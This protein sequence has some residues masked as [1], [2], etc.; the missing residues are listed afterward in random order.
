M[1]LSRQP[2]RMLL[3]DLRFRAHACVY[4]YYYASLF[5]RHFFYWSNKK[6]LD[7]CI[8]ADKIICNSVEL[9][10]QNVTRIIF[11]FHNAIMQI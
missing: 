2:N 8:A 7:H 10:K 11:N 9:T 6:F 1:L 4:W 5:C 3:L